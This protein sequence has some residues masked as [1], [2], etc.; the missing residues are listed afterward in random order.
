M[1]ENTTLATVL[2]QTYTDGFLVLKGGAVVYERYF[3][4]MTAGAI[5]LS[6]SVAKSV[7][8]VVAGI[9][10][11]RGQLDPAALVTTYL[12][13]LAQTAWRGTTL[14]Q[15]LDMTTGVRFNEDYTDPLSDMARM[16]V[17]CGWKQP[18]DGVDPSQWP[19]NV[20]QLILTLREST[21]PHGAAFA[22]RS[23]ETDV[24]AF[25]MERVSRQRLAQLVSEN[26][27]QKLGAE[28]NACFTI[29]AEGYALA[30][31][32]FN[33]CLRDYARF[34]QLLLEGGRGVIPQQWIEATRNENHRLFGLPYSAT[35][36]Q[37]AYHNQFWIEDAKSRNLMARGVFGQMIY[38]N[39]ECDMVVV[40]LS[41]WPDFLNPRFANATRSACHRI[42]SALR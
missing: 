22:Y 12:P 37:G 4:G 16:D 42:G 24:L 35:L 29:D 6:Q 34:G 28:Q 5:H 13:E 36:P 2:E 3:S 31:G 21:G 9:M 10:I 18:P 30:D 27:W 17:A 25:C 15:V 38:I 19:K 11:G 26:L 20:W 8:G 39:W 1:D 41:T 33:A 23:I 7:T 14:Q 40:K 32:G